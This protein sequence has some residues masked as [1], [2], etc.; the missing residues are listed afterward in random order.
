MNHK[1]LMLTSYLLSCL[2]QPINDNYWPI[3]SSF[4]LARFSSEVLCTITSVP[5]VLT[6]SC[7]TAICNLGML[8]DFRLLCL[9]IFISGFGLSL[10]PL[11][12]LYLF[13]PQKSML[14]VSMC[15]HNKEA[16]TCRRHSIFCSQLFPHFSITA[17]EGIRHNLQQGYPISGK[18]CGCKF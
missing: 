9:L 10:T 13:T 8:P 14:Q 17:W 6:I 2:G 11:I 7:S 1:K 3:S 16:K 12:L 5:E 18:L 15:I 4:P